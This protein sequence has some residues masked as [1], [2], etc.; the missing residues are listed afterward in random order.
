MKCEPAHA[1]VAALI[2]LQHT[3]PQGLGWGTLSPV[4]ICCS[5]LVSIPVAEACDGFHQVA[6]VSCRR[7]CF[8]GTS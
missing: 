1:H 4:H 8:I 6:Q 3:D 7:G 5:M 2:P